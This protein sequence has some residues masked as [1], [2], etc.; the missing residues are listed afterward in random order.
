MKPVVLRELCLL[1]ELK[2]Y[3]YKVILFLLTTNEASQTEIATALE[4]P[5]QNI[6]RAFKDLSSMDIVIRSRKVG[7]T[8]YWKIN[9]K[10]TLQVNGQLKLDV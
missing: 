9:P 4:V 3:H 6:N 5:K 7:S 1:K 2:T 8:I 10:P